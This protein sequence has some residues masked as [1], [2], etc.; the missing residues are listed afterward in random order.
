MRTLNLTGSESTGE[1]EGEGVGVS[2]PKS[3]MPVVAPCAV[4]Y[5][6]H[7]YTGHAQRLAPCVIICSVWQCPRGHQR[8]WLHAV[9]RWIAC[10][11][12]GVW[13]EASSR[14][15]VCSA[16]HC[17]SLAASAEP[18]PLTLCLP[19]PCWGTASVGIQVCP[20]RG[21]AQE[22]LPAWAPVES[23]MV[24]AVVSARGEPRMPR[25]ALSC[26]AESCPC[27]SC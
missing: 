1:S 26:S 6:G 23:H 16:R 9:W 2:G 13:G 3:E 8:A 15:A 10:G 27:P 7:S 5:P 25:Q 14:S 20:V 17:L 4:Q 21:I 24:G 11:E 22:P 19:S 18:V 12:R